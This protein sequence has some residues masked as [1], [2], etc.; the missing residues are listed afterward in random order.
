MKQQLAVLGGV[1]LLGLMLTC[2]NPASVDT[3][4]NVCSGIHAKNVSGTCHG[5]H[6][7]TPSGYC[8]E[9]NCHG[10]DLKGGNTGAPSCYRCHGPY[11]TI[12]AQHTKS[13]FGKKHYGNVC[14][15]TDFVVSCGE[16]NCHNGLSGSDGY[17]KS[18]SCTKCHGDP[19]GFAVGDNCPISS[20]HTRSM[21]GRKHHADVCGPGTVSALCGTST[22]HGDG[23]GGLNGGTG[24]FPGKKCFRCH[25]TES[26]GCD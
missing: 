15:S 9:A 20:S 22:C 23:L 10:S 21:D 11:W 24:T 3:P 16:T 19:T 13:I 5:P 26:L 12:L 14:T 2:Y 18:P 6:N 1:L 8:T 4:G 7:I 17:L 25:E